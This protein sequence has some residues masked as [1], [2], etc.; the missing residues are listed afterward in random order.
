MTSKGGRPRRLV[1]RNRRRAL[2]GAL[3]Q[4]ASGGVARCED[5]L[6]FAR[7]GRRGISSVAHAQE[8]KEL[9]AKRVSIPTECPAVLMARVASHLLDV[10]RLAR[11][12]CSAMPNLDDADH[13][14]VWRSG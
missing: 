10:R 1:P 9:R 14:N 12:H 6:L 8:L 11:A 13:T 2:R 7:V 3:S 5:Q 4:R